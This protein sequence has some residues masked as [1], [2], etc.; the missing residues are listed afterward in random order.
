MSQAHVAL[1]STKH[2]NIRGTGANLVHCLQTAETVTTLSR[3]QGNGP[4]L[5]DGVAVEARA[6]RDLLERIS[7]KLHVSPARSPKIMVA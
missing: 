3:A 2:Q 7:A 5:G 6:S 4:T 1:K